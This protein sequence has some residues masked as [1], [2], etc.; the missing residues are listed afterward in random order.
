MLATLNTTC[1]DL[2]D[3]NTSDKSSLVNAVNEVLAGSVTSN[4]YTT[5]QNF[6][7]IGDGVFD[8]SQAFIDAIADCQANDKVLIIPKAQYKISQTLDVQNIKI[9]GLGAIIRFYGAGTCF[10]IIHGWAVEISDVYVTTTTGTYGIYAKNSH[11]NFSKFS[12]LYIKGF[13]EG[14]HLEDSF[15]AYLDSIIIEDCSDYGIFMSSAYNARLSR[16]TCSGCDYGLSLSSGSGF[17]I[18]DLQI[19]GCI[20]AGLY[21]NYC[22]SGVIEDVYYEDGDNHV[23]NPIVLLGVQ[24]CTFTGLYLTMSD[25]SK[26]YILLDGSTGQY[27]INN[28]FSGITLNSNSNNGQFCFEM[29]DYSGYERNYNN[30][31]MSTPTFT[32]TSVTFAKGTGGRYQIMTGWGTADNQPTMYK[33]SND[34]IIKQSNFGS[35]YKTQATTDASGNATVNFPF[36]ATKDRCFVLDVRSPSDS[37]QHP[38]GQYYSSSV[39][40]T[41]LAANVTYTVTLVY[42]LG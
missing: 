32:S 33:V 24:N 38:N 7:A 29:N 26:S 36:G 21:L 11:L 37:I 9:K 18:T 22:N 16:V 19:A 17:K 34:V 5:P 10:N 13:T 25:N 4:F 42:S 40:L 30:I 31:I 28:I 41:G 14:M 27:N 35:V 2:S 12:G 23:I 8:D 6:G 15:L 39:V 1:G 3:L 20:T